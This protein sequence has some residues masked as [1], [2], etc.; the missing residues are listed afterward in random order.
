[1]LQTHDVPITDAQI[2]DYIP[3]GHLGEPED[4]AKAALFLVS[5]DARQISGVGLP[6]DGGELCRG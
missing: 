2:K 3:L 1:M 6:V 4:I 5:E